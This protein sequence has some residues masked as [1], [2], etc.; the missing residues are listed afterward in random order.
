MRYL[1]YIL[2]L[3][4]IATTLLVPI[5]KA[6]SDTADDDTALEFYW[7][8]ATGNVHHYSVYLSTDRGD[9]SVA[10]TTLATPTSENPY[11]LPIVAQDGR[12]YQVKVEAEDADGMT[13]PMSEPSDVV[14]CKLRSPGDENGLTAGDADGD[15]IVCSGDWAIL[16]KTWN[17]ERGS[18]PFD[19]RADFNY[20]DSV[21]P[22]DLTIVASNW[23]NIYSGGAAAPMLP[24]PIASDS[25]CRMKLI[26]RNHTR[27]GDEFSIDIVIEGVEELYT[28]DF[29]VSF[30]SGLMKINEIEQGTFFQA[31]TSNPIQRQKLQQVDALQSSSWIAGK[32][33]QSHGSISPTLAGMPLGS[34]MGRSSNGV[35]ATLKGTAISG[36][37]SSISVRNIRAYDSSMNRIFVTPVSTRLTIGVAKY[38]LAQNYPN[39][40]NPE[41][42]IP[43]ALAAE[44]GKTAIIIYDVIGEEVRRLELGHRSAG[45]YTTRERAAYW[46]G[47]NKDGINVA[48]G[49]YFYQIKAGDFSSIRKMVV[50]K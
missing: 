16:C 14:W 17:T 44:S 26:S 10:G 36:G 42:W 33:S 28:I 31:R 3:T 4:A 32:I 25:R 1:C 34:S 39:P 9:Y 29:E 27:V 19:Y 7:T 15:R 47:K 22:L 50:L 11:V 46:D 21:G 48:S 38:L 2:F 30:D 49:V 8:A 40:F 5:N 37:V 20:D 23:G 41:T 6:E 45:F 13:G 18:Q 12:Q 43:Y 24:R 35:V